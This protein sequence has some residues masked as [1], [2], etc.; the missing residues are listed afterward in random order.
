MVRWHGGSEETKEFNLKRL[1]NWLAQKS[2]AM[3]SLQREL[4]AAVDYY[5]NY[6]GKIDRAL[7]Q[8]RGHGSLLDAHLETIKCLRDQSA[9]LQEEL[10]HCREIMVSD[11]LLH[12]W[13]R[14]HSLNA[15]LRDAIGK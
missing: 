6:S 1:L 5:S 12:Q 2:D 4:D 11:E 14:E 10:V 9:M 8:P 15:L 7:G 13:R 3:A